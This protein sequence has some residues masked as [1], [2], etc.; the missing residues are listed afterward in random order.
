MRRAVITT[1][2]VRAHE[3][4]DAFIMNAR[5]EEPPELRRDELPAWASTALVSLEEAHTKDEGHHLDGARWYLPEHGLALWWWRRS[6]LG[7]L[8]IPCALLWPVGMGLLI[9]AVFAL[10]NEEVIAWRWAAGGT[11]AVVGAF[12]VS[13]VSRWFHQTKLNGLLFAP[14]GLLGIE[15][16]VYRVASRAEIHDFA[17]VDGRIV[18]I[19]GPDRRGWRQR[20]ST[21]P[22]LLEEHLAALRQWKSSGLLPTPASGRKRR[23][24]IRFLAV[25]AG[26]IGLLAFLSLIAV[27]IGTSEA[28]RV[29]RSFVDAIAAKD[30]DAAYELLSTEKKR[31]LPREEFE[32]S[33]P[34]KL[35]AATGF[36]VNALGIGGETAC[37]EGSLDGVDDAPRFVFHVH[38][39]G[40][41][42]RI[43]DWHDGG[44]CR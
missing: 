22:G 8:W 34:A 11:L 26:S 20:S 15:G 4:R 19:Y 40:D 17:L 14:P 16:D 2:V 31:G 29:A 38:D 39:D 42:E 9:W 23:K 41:M 37:V 13:R 28:S 32:A 44:R 24:R 1:I 21:A 12:G 7:A 6:F 30:F 43:A 5:S 36:T 18:A 35:R 10:S 27:S 25:I 3:E 33:L